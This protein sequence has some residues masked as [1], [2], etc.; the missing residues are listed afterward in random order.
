MDREPFFPAGSFSPESTSWRAQLAGDLTMS[1]FFD[2]GGWGMYP[3]L[4]FGFFL[5][6]C[7]ILFLIRPEPRYLASLVGL[8]ATTGGAG[9]LGFCTGVMNSLRFLKEVPT[10]DRFLVAA[11]GCEES[12]HCVVLALI[13]IVVA[14][15]F[16]SLGA[17]RLMLLRAPAAS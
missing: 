17:V 1:E 6:A 5:I 8:G 15:I 9:L 13:L 4:V 10:E 7:S 16:V 2:A 11:L 14:G 12:L 3:P